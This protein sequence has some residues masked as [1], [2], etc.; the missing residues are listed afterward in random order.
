RDRHRTYVVAIQQKNHSYRDGPAAAGE[1]WQPPI[2]RTPA[3]PHSLSKSRSAWNGPQVGY[4]GM[5]TIYRARSLEIREYGGKSPRAALPLRAPDRIKSTMTI[6][7][8]FRPRTP[9]RD[10]LDQE[11]AEYANAHPN[12]GAPP[13]CPGGSQAP[14]RPPTACRTPA[15]YKLD[16]EHAKT[17]GRSLELKL[18]YA[19]HAN[20]HPHRGAPPLRM[21][22]ALLGCTSWT[23]RRHYTSSPAGAQDHSPVLAAPL[24]GSVM[25][26]LQMRAQSTSVH[27]HCARVCPPSPPPDIQHV[28][29]CTPAHTGALAGL[30][31]PAATHHPRSSYD[32][33]TRILTAAARAEHQ[34]AGTAASPPSSPPRSCPYCVAAVS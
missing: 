4:I 17:R 29:S 25:Y 20:A 21:R 13:L 14:H 31:G 18:L 9:T 16:Q 33:A 27:L 23:A 1:C 24:Q 3:M 19:R 26:S 32:M 34:R 5:T 22:R 2:T 12:R 10:K 28:R 8:S 11:R 30:L 6:C 15:R 7:T